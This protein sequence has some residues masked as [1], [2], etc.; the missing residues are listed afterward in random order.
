VITTT[1]DASSANANYALLGYT[2]SVAVGAVG[3]KGV[4]T[5]ATFIGGPG[6]AITKN[7]AD[8]FLAMS[9]R[10]GKP[11]IPIFNAANKANTF[12][13]GVDSAASTAVKVTLILAQ[14]QESYTP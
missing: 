13:V 2:C 4:D 3:I 10:S 5:S 14:L 1:Y 12:V 8:Y 9:K 6:E 11:C 7:T